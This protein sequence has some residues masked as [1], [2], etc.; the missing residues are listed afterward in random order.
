[1]NVDTDMQYAFTHAIE[2]HFASR[3]DS[4]DPGIDKSVNDP[5][6]WGRKA[7]LAMAARVVAASEVLGSVGNTLARD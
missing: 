2:E 5:R 7:E 3:P 4:D 6:S 1:M